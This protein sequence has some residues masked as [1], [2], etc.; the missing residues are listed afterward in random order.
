MCVM[1][2]K[3]IN[4]FNFKYQTVFSAKFDKQDEYNQLLDE[5]KL[6]NISIINHNIT[7]TDIDKSDIK[8]SLEHQIQIQEKKDSGWRFDKTTSMVIDFYKTGE[9]KESIYEKL[10]V[11]S[12]ALKNIEN[13]V[14][15]CFSWSILA[16]LHPCNKFY[17]DRISNYTQYFND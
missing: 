14:R 16:S 3:L 5:R 1:N 11:R 10:P 17:P 13:N 6:F 7:E 4:Q 9:L 8:S 2:A 12:C 15:K